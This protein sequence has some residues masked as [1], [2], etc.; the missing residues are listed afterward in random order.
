MGKFGGGT[1]NGGRWVREGVIFKKEGFG[2]FVDD[3]EFSVFLAA[4]TKW[5]LDLIGGMNELRGSNL[6]RRD[7]VH[8]LLL[9]LPNPLS[10]FSLSLLLRSFPFVFF[11]CFGFSLVF[12]SLGKATQ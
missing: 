7:F 11:C 12:L 5:G 10:F 2:F 1:G 4:W 3:E 6:F 8:R 9:L